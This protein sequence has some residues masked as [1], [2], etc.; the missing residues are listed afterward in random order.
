MTGEPM[1]DEQFWVDASVLAPENRSLFE[2][3][4]MVIFRRWAEH[5]RASG[6]RLHTRAGL[7]IDADVIDAVLSTLDAERSRAD[8]AEAERDAAVA[9]AMPEAVYVDSEAVVENLDGFGSYMVARGSGWLLYERFEG[10]WFEVGDVGGLP[11]SR[12]V[13]TWIIRLPDLPTPTAAQE[14]QGNG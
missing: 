2:A 4:H 5:M 6:T 1:T 9:R 7:T 3:G 10:W 13:G 12:M 8:T 11:N 14:G